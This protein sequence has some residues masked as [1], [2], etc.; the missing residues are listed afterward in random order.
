M[1][2]VYYDADTWDDVHGLEDMP[3]YG[4]L[5]IL[6]TVHHFT[7]GNEAVQTVS[8]HPY[9]ILHHGQWLPAKENDVIDYLVSGLAIDALLVG[10]IVSKQ[11]YGDVWKKV[12]HDKSKLP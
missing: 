2:R 9:Y 3:R 6:Q 11:A 7:G 10:R 8:G 12:Q 1:W 4:V 5:A